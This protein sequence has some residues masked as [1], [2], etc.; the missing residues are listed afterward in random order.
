MDF[1]TYLAEKIVH[2]ATPM[3]AHFYSEAQKHPAGSK[4]HRE[5]M[6]FHHYHASESASKH[7][8]KVVALHHA[9]QHA[10]YSK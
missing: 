9:Q 6:A 2:A 3:A 8:N 4:E 5:N 1:E 7:G 10:E